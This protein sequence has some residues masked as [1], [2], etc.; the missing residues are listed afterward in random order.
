MDKIGKIE[1]KVFRTMYGKKGGDVA[2]SKKG[3]LD[4]KTRVVPEKALKGADAKSHGTA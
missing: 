1:I 2:N 4:K 3:F